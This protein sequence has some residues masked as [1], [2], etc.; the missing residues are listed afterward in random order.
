MRLTTIVSI[1]AAVV[2]L[3]A[4]DPIWSVRVKVRDPGNRPIETATLAVACPDT[5]LYSTTTMS[6][7]ST[8]MGEASVGNLGTQFPID[9]DI[10]VAKPGFRTHVIRYRDL[11]PGGPSSCDRVFAFD[12]VL[13]PE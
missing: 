9:C 5:T 10:Y 13:E 2:G 12:L 1:L 11:C 4:C 8:A 6:V 3:A 7:H